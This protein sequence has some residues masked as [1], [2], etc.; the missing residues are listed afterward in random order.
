MHKSLELAFTQYQEGNLEEA[1]KI[2]REALKNH[3]E[4]LQALHYLGVLS[5]QSGDYDAA[6]AYIHHEMRLNPENADSYTK[7][8]IVFLG[9]KEFHEAISQFQ[10]ALQINPHMPV[11]CYNLGLA[12]QGLNRLD[13]ASLYYQKA[14]QMK[15]DYIQAHTNL[16]G[17]FH[18]AGKL[19][20]AIIHYK[21][22]LKINPNFPD[23]LYNLA[24][25]FQQR[26][27][28]ADSIETLN[29]ALQ[30]L[31]DAYDIHAQLGLALYNILEIDK[32]FYH[33][34]KAAQLNPHYDEAHM[35]LGII[36]RERGQ[37]DE[38]E[39]HFRRTLQ[40]NPKLAWAYTN[41]GYLLQM[42]GQW[43][44]AGAY[45]REA[46]EVNPNL[47]KKNS[48]LQHTL[49]ES[50]QLQGVE[51]SS[52]ISGRFSILVIVNAYNR[53]NIT[54]LS[55]AQTKRYMTSWCC[56]Q[57]Y[58][59]HSSEYDNSFLLP[60]AD[61]V[62]QLPEKSDLAHLRWHQFRTF[63]Q[64][65]Y[66]FLYLTDNDVIH[67]PQYISALEAF[68]EIGKRKLP[69]SLYNSVFT[70]QPRMILLARNDI[71]LKTTAPG[72]SMFFDRKMVKTI[73]ARLDSADQHLKY[74]PWDN[75]VTALLG[76]PWVTPEISYLEHFGAGG[77]SNTDYKRDT[78]INPT[79]Y[80][81]ERRGQILRYLMQNEKIQVPF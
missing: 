80:L 65:D 73:M 62:I 8:G 64:S 44:E 29:K 12:F 16:G 51:T 70:L 22:V 31:P 23:I 34:Q 66:D 41:M 5:L 18:S 1:L 7:L 43:D 20:E 79:E 36:C 59:D 32:A 19:D 69:V 38:A 25:I 2:Y 60:Y 81:R 49:Q 47:S 42:K 55:L 3:P 9:K 39:S 35:Y 72:C 74:L 68:Y 75:K 52:K 40:I 17:I 26:L 15:P 54:Q 77:I 33:F 46:L 4:N 28:Y 57:V 78:A 76:L 27:Q 11:T 14:L 37:Y 50:G 53:K 56:L 45:F 67:D 58:N 71:L 30:L 48:T 21:N 61:E 6:I 13:D 63:L 24:L 10:K